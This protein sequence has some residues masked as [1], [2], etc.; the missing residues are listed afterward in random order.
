MKPFQ[1][2]KKDIQS[3]R[4]SCHKVTVLDCFAE[5]GTGILVLKKLGI[6]IEKVIYVEHDNVTWHVFLSNHSKE[7]SNDKMVS[8]NEKFIE[9]Y[10][11]WESL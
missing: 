6:S 5:V 11:S 4:S 2:C 7:Y 10:K 9:E 8:S 3:S 1:K